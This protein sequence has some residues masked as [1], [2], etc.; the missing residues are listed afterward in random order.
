VS[1]YTGK[2]KN[3]YVHVLKLMVL[4]ITLTYC[5][6]QSFEDDN[7]QKPKQHVNKA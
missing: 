6:T 1:L 3:V 7:S 2:S 5:S 4:L